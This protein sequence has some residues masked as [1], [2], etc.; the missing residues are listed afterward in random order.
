MARLCRAC[1]GKP[2]GF[3]DVERIDLLH[4]GV[5]DV[6]KNGG[7][8]DLIIERLALLGGKLFGVIHPFQQRRCGHDAAARRYG[9]CQRAASCLVNAGKSDAQCPK[10]AVCLGDFHQS[11]VGGFSHGGSSNVRRPSFPARNSSS[12]TAQ[13]RCVSATPPGSRKPRP[14]QTA[15][16]SASPCAN[17]SCR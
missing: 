11:F 12:T 10:G 6:G 15:S 9:A 13:A 14:K 16:N 17:G 2:R 3:Q 5:A 7:G 8:K 1:H 4:A